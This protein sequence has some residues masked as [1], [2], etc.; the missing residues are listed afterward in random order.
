MQ[1]EFDWKGSLSTYK[2]ILSCF[3]EFCK[4]SGVAVRPFL[5]HNTMAIS[6][7]PVDLFV[8]TKVRFPETAQKL[9]PKLL[10]HFCSITEHVW[11]VL[12]G[13][14]G[15]RESMKCF[16]RA[17]LGDRQI[18]CSSLPLQAKDGR[19][20]LKRSAAQLSHAAVRGE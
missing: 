7:A 4:Q 8:S 11:L 10:W 14:Y 3:C 6:R 18:T 12:C 5:S 15:D 16:F 9:S 1:A 13:K 20:L 17:P 19:Q 2:S